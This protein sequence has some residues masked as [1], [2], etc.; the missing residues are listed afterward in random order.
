MSLFRRK[1]DSHL[2]KERIIVSEGSSRFGSHGYTRLR[3]NVIYM[4]S[5]GNRKVIQL[6]SSMAKEGKTSVTANLAV[7]LGLTDKKVVVVDLD[8]RRPRLH[9]V[10]KLAKE[11]G[12]A[13]YMTGKL[14]R[15]E[16]IK[17]TSYKNVDLIT[18]GSEIYNPALILVSDKFKDLI[19]SLRDKYDFVLLD[20]APVLQVS[21][22]IHISKVSDGALFLVA[23]GKTTRAQVADA[24]KELRKNNIE[25]IGTLFTMYDKKKDA[26]YGYG[27]GGYY[28]KY[29]D[30]AYGDMPAAIE[31]PEDDAANG[32][33]TEQSDK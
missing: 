19:A 21:D 7:S 1:R 10:F 30:S 28:G 29:Y 14:P 11:N 12:I 16:L 32:S 20:C 6:E 5:D 27:Y 2:L 9:R 8:F 31:E 22:Y 24:V 17:H 4:N 13:E 33:D 26:R 23:Y 3:D 18:R 15:E 25:I